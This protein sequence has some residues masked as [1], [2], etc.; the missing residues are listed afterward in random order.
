MTDPS[1][2]TPPG[3]AESRSLWAKFKGHVLHPE[4][5]PHQVG[6]SFAIGLCI[7]FNP[8][9]G[10]HTWM[11]LVLCFVFSRLH[12]PLM[13]L[14]AFINNPWTMVP[15]ASI[16]AVFG[17]ALLGRG[18]H[19]NLSSIHW[20]SIGWRSFATREGFDG[21]RIMLKPVLLPYLVGGMV[22]SLLAL[23][24]GYFIMVRVAR[25]LR[26]MHLH[27]PHLHLPGQHPPDPH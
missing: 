19:L 5:T 16:S 21:M 13:F 1:P 22:L 14:A 3:P 20:K 27:L 4:M 11:V 26:S 18:W 9:I 2:A 10:L 17:N 8:F 15:I 7:A 6:L 24:L 25:R 12:R 23:P